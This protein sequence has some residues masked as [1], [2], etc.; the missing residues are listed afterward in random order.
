MLEF[1]R[2]M[3]LVE[4]CL[5]DDFGVPG[6]QSRQARSIVKGLVMA[7]NESAAQSKKRTV[8][9]KGAACSDCMNYIP[10]FKSSDAGYEGGPPPKGGRSESASGHTAVP[11]SRG[12]EL[13]H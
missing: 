6:V 2:A 11:Y 1:E 3:E 7:I 9:A 8:Q 10:P 4:K 13:W 5:Q 12:R